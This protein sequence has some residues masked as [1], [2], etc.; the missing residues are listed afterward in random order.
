MK[1]SR[2][3]QVRIGLAAALCLGTWLAPAHAAQAAPEVVVAAHSAGLDLRVSNAA[4]ALELRVATPD[5]E[6]TQRTFAAT[7]IPSFALYRGDG[8]RHP[9]GSYTWE[10]RS[11]A[12]VLRTRGETEAGGEGAASSGWTASGTFAIRDGAILT[13]GGS[14]ADIGGRARPGRAAAPVLAPFDQVIPDDLIVQGSACVGF[15]CVNGE[16]FGFDTIRMKENSTRIQFDDTSALAGFATN[17]WQ[18][19]AN[20]SASGGA[21][22]LG[23]VDQGATGNSETGTVVFQVGAGAPANAL[24]VSS[25][26]RVGFRTAVP[27]LDLHVNTGNTPSWRLEQ[28]SSGGFSPQTWDVA[29]NEANFFVRDVTSGSRLPFR[30]R[31]GAPTSSLDIN[32]TGNVGIGTA[33]P[34]AALD[35]VRNTGAV[36]TMARFANNKGIQTL[37]DRTDVGANDWQMSN[38]SA[39]FEISVPGSPIGQFSLNANG[40]LTIAGTQYLTGSSRAIK[41][42]FAPV[43]GREILRRL[44]GMPLTSWNAIGDPQQR[45]IG[46]IAEDWWATFGLGPDDKHIGMTDLGGVALAAI[47]GL[48]EEVQVRD[49]RLRAQEERLQALESQNGE[50]LARL[51]RLEAARSATSSN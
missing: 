26:G 38:F 43:D 18:I 27:V 22:F 40:N 41:E 16:A 24:N 14:E 44:T 42:N 7:S 45:H 19:R 33:S 35:I 30:I 11:V 4:G 6:V 31:P 39:T 13:E 25:T 9:D 23:F 2:S 10:L 5:G 21:S 29:G 46:P 20:S 12:P 17:N 8:S 32:A 36:A 1:R 3:S 34:S 37:F 50:L 49:E 15:D 28:N 47:K 48:S 51:A